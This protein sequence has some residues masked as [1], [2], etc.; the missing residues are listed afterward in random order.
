[1]ANADETVDS[2]N[3][4]TEE[5]DNTE[6]IDETDSG[7]ESEDLEALQEK[8][9]R[10]FERAKKAETEAKLLKA[11]R[12]KKE[13]TVKAKPAPVQTEVGLTPKDTLILM[14]Q[15]VTEEEDIDAVLEFAQFKKISVSEA[16]KLSVV[17]T[18]LAEKAEL[19]KTAQATNTGV[20]RRGTTKPSAETLIADAQKGRMPDD[21]DA[22][23]EARFELMKKK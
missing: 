20:A 21:A 6:E 8:N 17:K 14:N 1:M 23:A 12:L 22:L 2:P 11:E 16:L 5:V 7:S 19:R 15:K 18:L 3:D 4:T 13:E 9:K 10:L